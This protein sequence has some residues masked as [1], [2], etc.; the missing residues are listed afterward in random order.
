MDY[1]D[2]FG[3]KQVLLSDLVWQRQRGG[4]GGGDGR[5]LSWQSQAE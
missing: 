5:L 2:A 4:G 1:F 3:D